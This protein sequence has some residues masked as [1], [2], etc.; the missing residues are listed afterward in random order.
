MNN[1]HFRRF[2][3]LVSNRHLGLPLVAFRGARLNCG[4]AAARIVLNQFKL[5]R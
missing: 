3:G 1:R 5:F 2:D 4:S